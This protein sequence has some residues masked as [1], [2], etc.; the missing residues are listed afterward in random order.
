MTK[1]IYTIC[2]II[3]F[4]M[5]AGAATAFAT[6]ELSDDMSEEGLGGGTGTIYSIE[7]IAVVINDMKYNFASNARFLSNTGGALTKAMFKKGDFAQQ[8]VVLPK[9]ALNPPNPPIEAG[10]P[11]DGR[12]L[13]LNTPVVFGFSS[14]V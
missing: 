9:K 13:S 7:G 14:G 10:R 12:L 8:E 2:L 11:C 4:T 1:R 5:M 6:N 3:I